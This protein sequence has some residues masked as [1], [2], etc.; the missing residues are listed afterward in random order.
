MDNL[1]SHNNWVKLSVVNAKAFNYDI[2]LEHQKNGGKKYD[3][4]LIAVGRSIYSREYVQWF[5]KQF[6]RKADEIE[7]WTMAEDDNLFVPKPDTP[8]MIVGADKA[9]MYIIAPR[10]GEDKTWKDV[11][12]A[13]PLNEG[14]DGETHDDL[15]DAELAKVNAEIAEW[16]AEQNKPPT[17]EEIALSEFEDEFAEHILQF[18]PLTGEFQ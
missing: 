2:K 12:N 13:H 16:D 8:L 17:E 18:N 5:V 1:I 9:W 4:T 11:W 10:V 3:L 14:E 6:N 15:E 7:L